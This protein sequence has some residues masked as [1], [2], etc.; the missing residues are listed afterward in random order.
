MRTLIYKRTHEGDPDPVAGVFGNHNCMGRVRAWQYDAVI[1]IGGNGPE[2]RAKGIAEKVT[3]IGIGPTKDP[4]DG[5]EPHVTFD[6]FIYFGAEGPAVADLAP[7]LASR[8]Y[9]NNV[10]VLMDKVSGEERAEIDRILDLARAAP[11]SGASS[12]GTGPSRSRRD[13]C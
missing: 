3:W 12:R 11:R 4:E 6:H 9:A 2:P 13:A 10:R 1:G 7:T 8:I 5:A